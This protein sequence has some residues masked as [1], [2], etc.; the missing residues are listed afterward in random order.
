MAT[1]RITSTTT[2]IPDN[3]ITLLDNTTVTVPD[4]TQHTQRVTS[5][6]ELN[7]ETQTRTDVIIKES[8]YKAPGMQITEYFRT[9][10]KSRDGTAISSSRTISVRHQSS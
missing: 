3:T 10:I 8:V 1:I 9:K 2:T 7:S 4:N 6:I 5:S